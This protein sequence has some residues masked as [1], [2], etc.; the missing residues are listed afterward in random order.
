MKHLNQ[1]KQNAQKGFT[2]IE[3]MIVVAIIGVLAAIAL[4]A[5]SDYTK[6][7]KVSEVIL[8]ASSCRISVS[9][10]VS[11]EL[12]L[13]SSGAGYGCSNNATQYV[14]SVTVDD[15]GQITATAGGTTGISADID[16]NT[17]TLTPVATA[18]QISNGII[19]QWDCAGTIGVQFRPGSCR[20]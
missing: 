19:P 11:A 8:A 15:A 9:E 5:Y 7:A 2:L 13:A 1:I 18:T 16:G 4:P 3:L 12:S 6:R 20:D 17:I 14:A 10:Y